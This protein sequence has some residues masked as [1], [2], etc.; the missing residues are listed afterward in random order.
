MLR[1]VVRLEAVSRV[2]VTTAVRHADSSRYS[3]YVRIVDLG[4]GDVVLTEPM[5]ESDWRHV[6]PNPR[7]GTRGARGVSATADR[8]VIAN[9]NTIFVFDR[10][11]AL[12]TTLT[13]PLAGALHDILAEDDGV[14]VTSANADLLLKLGWDGAVLDSWCWR[15]DRALVRTLGFRS[16]P[17]FDATLDYRDP[18]VL[19]S[20]AHNTIHLN[21][22]ARVP[23]GMLLSFGRV[24]PARTLL[25]RRWQARIGRAASRLGVE[26]R[27]PAAPPDV[28]ASTVGGSSHAVVQLHDDGAAELLFRILDTSV[29]NHN[30]VVDED[31]GIVY[32]DSN[33][34]RLVA[35]T[36]GTYVER[37]SVAIPGSPSFARG[38]ARLEGSRYVVGSQRPLA[39]HTVDLE[40]GAL[41]GTL[42]LAGEANESVYAIAPLPSGFGDIPARLFASSRDLVAG[43]A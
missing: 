15:D 27:R 19:R 26:R 5:P 38:L 20:G 43:A 32:A 13:H 39:L 35:C 14:W 40:R 3:G 37:T 22:L 12:E 21:A 4:T 31:G 29:P 23:D 30:L 36:T 11:W 25:Q 1:R 2:I 7:G 17:P 10:T 42:E 34:G 24:L 16:V 8:L 33:A 9:S 18:R 41:T 6:D 28:P